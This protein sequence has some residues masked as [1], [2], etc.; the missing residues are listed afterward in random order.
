MVNPE[1]VDLDPLS[2]SDLAELQLIIRDHFEATQS[3]VA[4]LLLEDWSASGDRF[5]KIM[6]KDLKRVL[7]LTEQALAE[8]L[9]PEA[10]VLGGNRG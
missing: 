4:R 3:E 6:P 2:D 9:S 1:M 8:G 5:T 7:V 10:L